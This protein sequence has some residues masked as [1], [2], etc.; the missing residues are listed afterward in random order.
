VIEP[1]GACRIVQHN[2]ASGNAPPEPVQVV[3]I[4]AAG[5]LVART[6]PLVAR[7]VP[8]PA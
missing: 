2:L 5:F 8:V 3:E 7:C 4:T 6:P 1:L